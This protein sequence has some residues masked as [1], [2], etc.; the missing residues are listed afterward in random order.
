MK[1]GAVGLM[2]IA[3]ARHTLQLPPGLAARM[4]IGAEVAP[5][6]PALIST[7]GLGTKVGLR[8]DGALAASGEGEDRRWRA[9]CL[10]TRIDTRLTSFA[11]RLVDVSGERFG[12]LGAFASELIGRKRPG[13]CGSGRIGP[14]DVDQNAN[15]YECN[16]KELVKQQIRCHD[17]VPSHGFERGLFYRIDSL[18]NYPLAVGT[19]P[20][21]EQ[22]EE[23][24]HL[25][26][27]GVE[28]A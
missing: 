11:Y 1:N 7:I 3:L 14:P 2:E 26:V 13:R 8:V 21:T 20:R 24:I 16:Q 12:L 19:G 17:D 28:V 10:G 27:L 15:Q 22:S 6:E 23:F 4:P 9:G 18:S 25:D 5:S